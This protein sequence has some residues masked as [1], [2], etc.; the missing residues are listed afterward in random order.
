M[1]SLS[2]EAIC[3]YYSNDGSSTVDFKKQ[4]GNRNFIVQE[5]MRGLG[6]GKELLKRVQSYWQSNGTRR[7]YL[8]TDDTRN[9]GFYEHMGLPVLT[10]QK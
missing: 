7:S 6:I 2:S 9:Y 1:A 3:V 10:K 4:L 5:K 8:Y